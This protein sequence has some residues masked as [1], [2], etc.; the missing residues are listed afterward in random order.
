L[1]KYNRS[2][3]NPSFSSAVERPFLPSQAVYPYNFLYI[4]KPREN[5]PGQSRLSFP[6]Q[7]FYQ[8]TEAAEHKHGYDDPA[9]RDFAEFFID[10]GTDKKTEY[11]SGEGNKGKQEDVFGKNTH[12]RIN[13]DPDDVFNKEDKA[14][15]APESGAVLG[16]PFHIRNK[17]KINAVESCGDP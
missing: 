6:N 15:I 3:F 16:G 13:D 4:L 9:Y 11:H 10:P 17:E 2:I 12:H 8:D 14:Y 5:P 7:G 1:S